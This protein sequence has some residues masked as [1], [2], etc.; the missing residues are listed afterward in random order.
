MVIVV[1][2]HLPPCMVLS[3]L[4]PLPV[5][6]RPYCIESTLPSGCAGRIHA[7]IRWDW[8]HGRQRG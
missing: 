4:S 8:V 1:V 2:G 7:G 6:A 5:P 3:E